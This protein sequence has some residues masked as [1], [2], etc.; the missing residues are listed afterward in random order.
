MGSYVIGDRLTDVQLA[1]NLG[2]K[3]IL[4]N[5]PDGVGFIDFKEVDP[6]LKDTVVLS[7]TNWEDIYRFLKLGM[8]TVWVRRGEANP[9]PTEGDLKQADITVNDLTNLPALI[10]AL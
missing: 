10:A 1:K 6:S 8:R 5:N 2:S 4:I 7:T 3:C 9:D